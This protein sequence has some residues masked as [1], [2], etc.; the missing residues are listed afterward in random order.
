MKLFVTAAILATAFTTAPAL[1]E[2]RGTPA[3][4]N[5][6]ATAPTDGA[7]ERPDPTLRYR[8]LFNVT[9][10]SADAS[11]PSPSLEK[12]ARFLNLLAADGVHPQPGDVVAIVYGPATPVIATDTVYAARTRAPGNPNLPLIAKLQAAGV[13]VAVC[14]QALHG[15]GIATG[16]VAPGVR[17]DVSAITT[18]ATLQLRGWALIPD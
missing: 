10:A 14:S 17:V 9:R 4:E 7:A 15:N 13:T 11:K 3:I 6:G 16:N 5:Y 2:Q 8:V 18:Q 12:I 1:A